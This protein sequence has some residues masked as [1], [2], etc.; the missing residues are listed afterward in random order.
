MS[1][2]IGQHK[3]IKN[4]IAEL[5]TRKIDMDRYGREVRSLQEKGT[6]RTKLQATEQK[7]EAAKANYTKLNTEL[8]SDLPKL[9]EDRIPFF[10]PVFATVRMDLLKWLIIIPV[11]ECTC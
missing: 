3:E 5:E 11:L 6:N 2:Y 4:R 8:M 7:L 10:D 1:K 9:H